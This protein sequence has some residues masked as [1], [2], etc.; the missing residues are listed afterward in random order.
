MRTPAPS[1]V[2]LTRYHVCSKCATQSN[3]VRRTRYQNHLNG[4]WI[5]FRCT[6][7]CSYQLSC[8]RRLCGILFIMQNENYLTS[9]S[10]PFPCMRITRNLFVDIGS[11]FTRCV[12]S[13]TNFQL[14]CMYTDGN[15]GIKFDV[16]LNTTFDPHVK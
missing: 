1:A 9:S 8:H 13:D 7:F 4:N 14:A 16:N 11:I 6:K 15:R 5:C 3:R 12:F 10:F 2:H